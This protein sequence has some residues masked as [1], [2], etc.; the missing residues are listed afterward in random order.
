MLRLFEQE[1][2]RGILRYYPKNWK[3]AKIGK[4]ALFLVHRSP[5]QTKKWIFYLLYHPYIPDEWVYLSVWA[6]TIQRHSALL[7]KELK[8]SQNRKSCVVS[9]TQ[10]SK[11]DKKMNILSIVPSLYPWRMSICMV[12]W[13]SVIL[14][15]HY[16]KYN[17]KVLFLQVLNS[18]WGR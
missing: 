7:P 8:C 16:L 2:F 14:T 6:G 10:K 18:S 13:F 17:Y 12:H 15:D 1:L 4:V 3:A 9:S 11:T 5:R